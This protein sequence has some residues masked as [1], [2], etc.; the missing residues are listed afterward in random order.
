MALFRSLSDQSISGCGRAIGLSYSNM[1]QFESLA[2]QQ[3]ILIDG[4]TGLGTVVLSLISG[5]PGSGFMPEL[6]LLLC[7]F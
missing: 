1:M 5:N 7:R 6:M 4:F 3:K 2:F